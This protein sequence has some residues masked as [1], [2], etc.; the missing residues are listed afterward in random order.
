M[1][2]KL[3]D[4]GEKKNWIDGQKGKYNTEVWYTDTCIVY[5]FWVKKKNCI[6]IWLKFTI[7]NQSKSLPSIYRFINECTIVFIQ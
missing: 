1:N 2:I 4:W 5:A 3:W 6:T 7:R